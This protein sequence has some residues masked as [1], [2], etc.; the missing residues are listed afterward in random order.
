MKIYISKIKNLIFRKALKLRFFNK[1]NYLFLFLILL[2]FPLTTHALI[3]TGIFDFF[4][5]SLEGISELTLPFTTFFI[6]LI[7]GLILSGLILNLS[8]WL[9]EIAANPE[10]LEIMESAMVQV[11]WQ[12]TSSLANTAIIIVLIIIGISVI[13]D[14]DT[15]SLKKTLPNILIVALLVNFSL[16]LVGGIV[17][18]ANIILMTFFDN[19]IGAQLT[20]AIFT[21]WDS[22]WT[23]LIGYTG[24]LVVSFLVP[25]TAPMAQFAFITTTTTIFLPTIISSVLQVVIGILIGSTLLL[26]AFLFLARIYIIQILAVLSPLA[27][28]SWSLPET[29]KWWNKWLNA[30]V[31]WSFLG[32]ILFFF[33]LLST[34]AVSPL[35]PE[36]PPTTI[37][38]FEG[39][40]SIFIYYIMLAAFL[41]VS[42]NMTKKFMP[43]GAQAI[44]SQTKN[45]FT[46]FKKAAAP[47]TRPLREGMKGQAAAGATKEGIEEKERALEQAQ[48][49][50]GLAG[51]LQ[52]TWRKADLK[53]SKWQR[54]VSMARG[55]SPET[56]LS[57]VQ[58]K[59][60]DFIK[61]ATPEELKEKLN[62]RT[63]QDYEKQP[64]LNEIA[65]RG[66]F[67][68]VKDTII[69][70]WESLNKDVKKKI[71]KSRPDIHIDLADSIEEGM[72]KMRESINN[73]SGNDVKDIQFN[74]ITN[75]TH[76]QEIASR[77]VDNPSMLK[78]LNSASFSQQQNFVTSLQGAN[79]ETLEKFTD[80]VR[81]NKDKWSNRIIR[82]SKIK[83]ENDESNNDET[84]KGNNDQPFTDQYGNPFKK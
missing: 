32:A 52:R 56:T 22:L 15:Y 50:T 12:F 21:S 84:F 63:T 2:L 81:K 78:S 61:N 35:R 33:L 71:E 42:A 55:K 73:M 45:A 66:D 23:T 65:K 79:E 74:K 30:L 28:V 9:L 70:N 58:G 72:E 10:N 43:E 7:I 49:K 37:I 83:V 14:R 6:F 76:R 16:V 41:I 57:K 24:G 13:L 53:T 29:K 31:G 20:E 40:G 69:N 17:D 27:F 64:I 19:D 39:I 47:V 44:I 5:S 8:V 18:I 59:N 75:E 68:E 34:V 4:S 26:Y 51:S 82:E 38:G 62:S 1:K 46:G 54:R 3:G 48:N 80:H 77:V 11:G 25:F 67:D 36:D 60:S